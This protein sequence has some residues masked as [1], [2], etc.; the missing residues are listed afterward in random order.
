ML[1]TSRPRRVSDHRRTGTEGK[2]TSLPE[3]FESDAQMRSEAEI[4]FDVKQT[5]G[6]V[7][8]QWFQMAE[9]LHFDEAL[10]MESCLIA[11]DFQSYGLVSLMVETTKDKSKRTF[12]QRLKHFESIR[13]VITD[14]LSVETLIIVII[15]QCLAQ[16]LLRSFTNIEDRIVFN[17]LFSLEF[18]QLMRVRQQRL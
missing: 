12:A 8:I 3:Q 17:D 4:F 13:D 14:S 9:N 5:E 2:E 16:D 7:G 11:K 1:N 18:T 15:I 6:M 10:L